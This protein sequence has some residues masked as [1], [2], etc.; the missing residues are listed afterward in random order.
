VADSNAHAIAE[1]IASRDQNNLYRASSYFE[2]REKYRAFCAYYAL[3]RVVDDRIDGLH[4][5]LRLSDQ[6]RRAEHEV[7]SAWDA[8]V[9]IC[10]QGG[11]VPKPIVRQ[12]GLAD[13]Q[14]L[15]DS[16][17]ASLEVF[18]SPPALWNNFFQSMHWDLDHERFDTWPE[19][20]SYA[21]GASVAPTTV[22]LF[23]ITSQRRGVSVSSPAGFD[24][25]KCGRQ[26]GVFAYLAHILRD[27]AE[28]LQR[29]DN[30]LIYVC[31][32]DMTAYGVT[33]QLLFRD[34][35]QG[36][37]SR[38]T[39]RLVAELLARARAFLSSA[40]PLMP[41][42]SGRL[43]RDCEFILDLIV[44][45]YERVLDKIAACAFEVMGTGHRLTPEEKEAIV[46]E[47]ADRVGFKPTLEVATR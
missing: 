14:H 45:V 42:L 41:C 4:T 38:A 32:E 30:G 29:G 2:D 15:F 43:D 44:T 20:L 46:K 19:F 24:V 26:L 7:V 34:A 6:E 12:C 8:G 18:R 36:R 39:R 47:V 35:E 25:I 17:A 22:Y 3:M 37:S 33:E 31:G 1:A 5:R 13:A 11:V 28:D 27:L 16:F 21:E 40:R 10:Y 23:L 9:R